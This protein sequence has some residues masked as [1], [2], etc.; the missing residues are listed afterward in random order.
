MRSHTWTSS[1][2]CGSSWEHAIV[3]TPKDV[4]P[5]NKHDGTSSNLADHVDYY[6]HLTH[7]ISLNIFLKL[8]IHLKA[9][10]GAVSQIAIGLSTGQGPSD[11]DFSITIIDSHF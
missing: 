1:L 4:D 2:N 9:V 3:I 8:K 6:H 7:N 5:Q 11:E 10:I